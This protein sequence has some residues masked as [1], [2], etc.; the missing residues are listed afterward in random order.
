MIRFI[1][2]RFAVLLLCIFPLVVVGCASTQPTRFYVLSPV[3]N[4][5][6]EHSPVQDLAI[7]IGPVEVPKYLDRAQIVTRIGKNE[8]NLADF[9]YWAEPLGKSI[10]R[11]LQENLSRLLST[12]LVYSYP[13]PGSVDIS[14]QIN[15]DIICFEGI[16]GDA[17]TLQARWALVEKGLKKVLLSRKSSFNEPIGGP[18]YKELVA[19]ENRAIAALSLEI[20]EGIRNI[21]KK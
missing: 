11:V 10:S 21:Y 7:G 2:R 1:T 19:A 18:G 14:C 20:A 16:I 13:W 6:L 4:K 8:L 12:D 3:A 17:V 5:A 15:V 9:H